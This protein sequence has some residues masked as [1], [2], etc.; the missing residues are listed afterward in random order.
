MDVATRT[1]W[2]TDAIHS[3]IATTTTC[4]DGTKGPIVILGV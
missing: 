2:S 4:D 3:R 1:W